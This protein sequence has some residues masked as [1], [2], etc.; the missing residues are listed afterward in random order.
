[1]G[2]AQ[3]N[4]LIKKTFRPT[5]DWLADLGDGNGT[6]ETGVPYLH[7]ARLNGIYPVKV[8][9]FVTP[10]SN[11]LTVKVGY[12]ELSHVFQVLGVIRRAGV[13]IPAGTLV[14][15]HAETHR[16]DAGDPV[17]IGDSQIIALLA[18]ASGGMMVTVLP[19]YFTF[20]GVVNYLVHT[21][22]DM[23]GS[24][25]TGARYSL[26]VAD[27]DGV[28][29]VVDGT[30]V[31]SLEV[32]TLGD[33]PEVPDDHFPIALVRLHEGQTALST[34]FASPDVIPLVWG[35]QVGGGGGTD[36]DAIHDN[37]GGEI[38]AVA[39]K[40]SPIGADLLLIEDSEAS[41]AK[42]MVQIDN[43]PSG[44]SA[45]DDLSDVSVPS[46]QDGEGLIYNA[47]G[48]E[49]EAV[50][51]LG[52][53]VNV[54]IF[55]VEGTLSINGQRNLR[56]WNV[57]GETKTILKVHIG[58][59]TAP[60]TQ[61]IIADIHKNAVTIFTNQAHRPQIAA[62]SKEGYTVD[63][64]V[65]TWEVGQYLQLGIDQVGS[66]TN[67]ED[68]TVSIYYKG[69]AIISGAAEL[70]ALSDVN[71]PSPNEGDVLAWDDVNGWWEAVSSP[72]D[73]NAIHD[74]VSGE[75]SSITEKTTPVS[76]D[77]IL[78]EDSAASNAKKKVQVG[79]LP[80]GGGGAPTIATIYASSTD[81]HSTQNTWEDVNSMS[82]SISPAD[83]NAKL[84]CFLTI[85]VVPT[86]S[87]WEWFGFRFVLD[88]STYSNSFYQGK[89]VGP[90]SSPQ[91]VFNMHAVFEGVSSGSRTVKVQWHD[92]NSNLNVN[93]LERRLTVMVGQ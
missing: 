90:A 30:P 17:Y 38:A 59:N 31:A 5:Q 33:V 60:T 14:S 47:T 55:T 37:V 87:N 79:N 74:N 40:V 46:P 51:I 72:S 27:V 15:H 6:V 32:L 24:I 62:E 91:F 63:I 76:A 35:N 77:L 16:F 22:I 69:G 7:H 21:E 41:N 78:I 3:L 42:K 52:K 84:L 92:H 4:S 9:N 20:N 25:P 85:T 23:T 75:I 19:G 61:A 54:A 86:D 36:E 1:M 13:T 43:L 73:Q 58:V 11:N 71:V 57:T 45:L 50:Q 67:G 2:K 12:E 18:N 56:L 89:N 82:V 26:L 80:G 34:A 29:S 8:W 68:L 66:G 81:S 83:D 65:P 44:A 10:P 49:W 93:L 53:M 88:G 39:E 28:I 48:G 70:D 64:D